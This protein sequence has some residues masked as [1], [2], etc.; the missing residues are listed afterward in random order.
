M[1]DNPTEGQTEA[2]A[3]A[4]PGEA[5]AA[6]A[7]THNLVRIAKVLDHGE[8]NQ[9]Q[10]VGVQLQD[11]RGREFVMLVPPSEMARLQARLIAAA[12]HAKRVREK[13]SDV[14]TTTEDAIPLPVKGVSVGRRKDEVFVMR[15]DLG[16]GTVLE[17]PLPNESLS[18]LRDGFARAAT[19]AINMEKAK[20][21]NGTE[22]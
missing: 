16:G 14:E 6:E 17:S 4:T 3:G 10:L 18:Q 19:M 11:D 5:P 8:A 1:S 13:A 2:Q 21:A 7:K 22:H 9:G 12:A 20:A 15:I